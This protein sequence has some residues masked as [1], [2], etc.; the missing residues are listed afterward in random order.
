MI[1]EIADEIDLLSL[2][3]SIE[4][5]RAGDAGRGFA[6][7]AQQ[8]SKLATETATTV[9][10]IQ[11]TT[12]SVQ[13]AFA[14]LTKSSEKLLSFV[15]ETATPDYSKFTEIGRQYGEDAGLFGELSRNMAEMIERIRSTMDEVNT[16]VQ[17][18]AEGSEDTASRSA[19][20][21]DAVENVSHAI[22]SVA[23]LA[24]NQQFTAN[25]LTEIVNNFKL[26]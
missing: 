3:A 21:T 6:V 19:D 14:D 9:R 11:E 4:A 24:T 18:I 20:V 26:N 23:Q 7:V 12:S 10:K 1:N 17:N 15:N 8:I 22:D 16:A 13:V 25:A 5:A 2:N